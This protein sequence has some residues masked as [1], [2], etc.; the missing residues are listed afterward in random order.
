VLY[1]GDE[2]AP[3]DSVAEETDSP[4]ELW[5]ALAL[6]ARDGLEALTFAHHSAGG[7]VATNWAIPPDPRFEPLTEIVSVH[8]SSEAVDSPLPIYS[9]VVGNTVRDALDRGYQLGFIGSG[10]SHDGHP[11]ADRVGGMR[12]GLAAILAEERTR[13]SV[14]EALRARRVYATNGPRILL[15]FALGEHR[16]GSIR[17]IGAKAAAAGVDDAIFVQVIAA[18]PLEKVELVRS[19]KVVDGVATVGRL[20]VSL[21]RDIAGLRPGEYVYVRAVQADGGA[22]WSSP[23]WIAE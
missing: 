6:A 9:P 3:I 5:G 21:T 12:G 8:G 11:G 1:F 17:R 10:D 22:A 4:V 15:R 18:A 2:G 16:M 20:E 23:I 14:R 13:E 19:G 7:P